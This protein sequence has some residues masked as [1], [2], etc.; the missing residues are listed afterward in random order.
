VPVYLDKKT[1]RYYIEFRYKKHRHKERLPAGT[2]KREAERIEVKVKNDLMFQSHGISDQ[3]HITIE[4]FVNEV[5]GPVAENW[6]QARWDRLYLLLKDFLPFVKGRPM[7]SIKAADLERFKQSRINLLTKH[8]TQRKPAT[9][10]REMS[11]I[12]S[13][14]TIAV[15]N[16]IIDYNPCSRIEK[17]S[18]DNVQTAILKPEDEAKLFAEIRSEWARDICKVILNTGLRQNDVLGLRKFNVDLEAE[19]I[20]VLQGKTK[21]Q[22]TVPMNE[23]V[24]AIITERW[25]NRGSLLFPSPKTGK[26]GKSIRKALER[27]CDRAGI[28]RIGSRTSRRTFGT[29]LHELK[30]DDS[31][32]A[33]LLGHGDLRSV[34]RYKRGTKIKKEAVLSLESPTSPRKANEVSVYCIANAVCYFVKAFIYRGFSKF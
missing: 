34:H 17:L 29:R 14:F 31:T 10:E 21:R 2:T 22:V 11:I 23:T 26:Q 6:P 25:A 3:S 18:F 13:L 5:V 24:K 27:A 19:E 16:D 8:K 20:T 28:A 9:V 7:R 15:K 12:S 4:T 1:N 32:V 33:Q 30:F